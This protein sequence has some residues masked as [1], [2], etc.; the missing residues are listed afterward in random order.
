LAAAM[1]TPILLAAAFRGNLPM[2]GRLIHPLPS[3][4]GLREAFAC[5]LEEGG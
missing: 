4:E 3:L 2:K 1:G 5:L